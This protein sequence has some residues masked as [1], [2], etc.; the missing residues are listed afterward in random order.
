LLDRVSGDE[1]NEEE[2]ERDDE[3]DN[4]QGVEDALEERFQELVP[5]PQFRVL[6]ATLENPAVSHLFTLKVCQLSGDAGKYSAHLRT[7]YFFQSIKD[8]HLST[9]K[10]GILGANPHGM[11]S[12]LSNQDLSDLIGKQLLWV[13]RNY[14]AWIK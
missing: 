8:R 9:V 12:S 11:W 3:P 7:D 13:Q 1:M 4:W 6:V 14:V 2:N 10:I 5:S